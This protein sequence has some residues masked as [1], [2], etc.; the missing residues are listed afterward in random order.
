[1]LF[2]ASWTWRTAAFERPRAT[3]LPALLRGMR[4]GLSGRVSLRYLPEGATYRAPAELSVGPI[5]AI[6]T[7]YHP[8]GRLAQV[9]ES[10]LGTCALVVVADNTPADNASAAE[11]L[12]HR[13]SGSCVPGG[14]SA[15][16]RR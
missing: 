16:P 10:A 2:L 11:K 12:D 9:V 13:G 15:W 8:D 4:D 3:H 14:T 6:V 1:V 5:T 7:A